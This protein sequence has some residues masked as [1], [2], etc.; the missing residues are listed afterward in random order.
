MNRGNV[1]LNANDG[2]AGTDFELTAGVIDI[3][4]RWV[5]THG[6]CHSLALALHYA[7]GW[8]I[9]GANDYDIDSSTPNH[10]AVIDPQGRVFDITGRYRDADEWRHAYAARYVTHHTAE[11]LEGAFDDDYRDPQ[12]DDAE[13]WV[14][15][16]LKRRTHSR[17]PFGRT[18]RTV[19][20]AE[21]ELA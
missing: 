18:P 13:P 20:R 16:V 4:A 1:Y 15:P 2:W 6:Q 5:F 10:V 12:A 9:V 8:D 17:P 19:K 11:D 7:T 14:E 3:T 21:W